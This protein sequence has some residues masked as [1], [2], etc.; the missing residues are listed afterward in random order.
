MKKSNKEGMMNIFSKYVWFIMKKNIYNEYV[1]QKK[2]R[3]FSFEEIKNMQ[4]KR[5]KDLLIFSNSHSLFYQ[6]TF[7]S[8]GLEPEDIHSYDDFSKIPIINKKVLRN[9]YHKI[10]V[11]GN[12]E[13]DYCPST[14]SGT[15]GE[16]FTFLIDKKNEIPRTYASFMIN[17]E[18]IGIDPFK[19]YNELIIKIKPPKDIKTFGSEFKYSFLHHLKYSFFSEPIGLK[20]L[21][22]KKDKVEAIHSLITDKNIAGL[23]G[24]SSNIIALAKYFKIMNISIKMKYII[25]IAEGILKQQKQ[26]ISD[27]F[28]CPVYMDYG[29]SECMRMGFECRQHKGYHM[30]IYNYFF[31]YLDDDGCPCNP[32]EIANIVVTNLNNRVFPLIR[33]SIGDQCIV[34]DKKCT[35]A[36]NFPLVS[37]IIGRKSDI[38]RTSNNEEIPM[39][40]LRALLQKFYMY[41]TQYQFKVNRGERTILLQIIP[42]SKIPKEII[43]ELGKQLSDFVCHS[44]KINIEFVNEIQFEKTGKTPEIVYQNNGFK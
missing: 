27:V 8:I 40:N 19:K 3:D 37:Q 7:Q 10:L 29:A 6:K 20:S 41:I 5:L 30:D 4:W 26:L 16:P 9:N 11:G 13:R 34:T 36:S 43:E 24:Y 15:T 32:G 2:I 25:L 14:T 22:V 39:L 42:T 17:K 44:M 12:C 23:Y 38:L 31:E 35:C 28:H 21:D 33:Y 1:K 18:N